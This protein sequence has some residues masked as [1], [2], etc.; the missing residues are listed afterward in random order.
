MRSL[1]LV[2][3]EPTAGIFNTATKIRDAI[4]KQ[5]GNPSKRDEA[6]KALKVANEDDEFAELHVRRA[7]LHARESDMGWRVGMSENL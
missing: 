5:G 3:N 4:R 1:A 6:P 2:C 7:Q